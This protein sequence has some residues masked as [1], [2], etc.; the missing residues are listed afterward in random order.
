MESSQPNVDDGDPC[1]CLVDTSRLG[2]LMRAFKYG[3]WRKVRKN[4]FSR[5][6]LK[7]NPPPLFFFRP[8]VAS[9]RLTTQGVFLLYLGSFFVCLPSVL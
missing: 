4:G 5:P 9:C 7:L 2:I 6:N 1:Y 3:G 8:G